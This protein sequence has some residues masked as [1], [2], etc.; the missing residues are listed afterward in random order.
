MMPFMY[1][2]LNKHDIDTYLTIE[3]NGSDPHLT[4]RELLRPP[5]KH[6]IE[7]HTDGVNEKSLDD[8]I[9]YICDHV[10]YIRD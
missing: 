1:Y 4:K 5:V 2:V 3:L 8:Y 9:D 7:S 10:S 6:F